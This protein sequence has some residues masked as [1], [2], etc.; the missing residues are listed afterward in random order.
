MINVTDIK[1]GMVIRLDGDMFV[2][3]DYE[4]I[5]PGKGPAYMQTKLRNLIT[6][7]N[8]EKRLNTSGKVEDVFVERREME[9]LYDDGS[10]LVFMDTETYEQ[11]HLSKDL[12]GDGVNFLQP[13]MRV[14]VSFVEGAAVG[15]ELPASVDL[16]VTETAPQL[17]GA[18]LTNKSKPAVLETGYRVMVPSFIEQGEVIRV[19]TRSGEYLERV[20]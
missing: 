19:D 1:K 9:Y 11:H 20:K 12:I 4:Q 15:V 14:Q 3:V 2:V 17:K 6:G 18:T 13:N 8:I 10:S 16:E 5:K 7:T